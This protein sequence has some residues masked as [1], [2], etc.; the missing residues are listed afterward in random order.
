M[1]QRKVKEKKNYIDLFCGCGGL[2][3]GLESAGF[4]LIFANELSPMAAETYAYNLI[5][6]TRNNPSPENSPHGIPY[7]RFIN[8]SVN[9]LESKD[10]RNPKN[11]SGKYTSDFNSFFNGI[12]PESPKLLVGDVSQLRKKIEKKKPSWL[13]CNK[14]DLLAGGPPCQSFSLA[15]KREKDN[16]R[17]KLFI[18][19]VKIAKLTKPKIVLL[20]NVLG[21]TAPFT[22]KDGTKSYPWLDV[23]KEFS[24]AGYIP[25]PSLINAKD[26]GVPQ[27]RPR[28]ILICLRKD[29]IKYLEKNDIRKY[30]N[31]FCE[32]SKAAI[33]N[34]LTLYNQT[35][36]E[37]ESNSNNPVIYRPEE[38]DTWPT[39]IFPKVK[40]HNTVNLDDALNFKSPSSYNKALK[41]SLKRPSWI[42][43]NSLPPLN[44]QSRTHGI[45]TRARFRILRNL[46]NK[47]SIKSIKQVIDNADEAYEELKNKKVIIIQEDKPKRSLSKRKASRS[48]LISLLESLEICSENNHTKKRDTL[49]PLK[50][51]FDQI[52]ESIRN[53]LVNSL[54]SKR[55]KLEKRL[56]GLIINN[57]TDD[58][59]IIKEWR[60]NNELFND[61][62]IGKN[63]LFLSVI[64]QFSET[65]DRKLKNKS[66]FKK[67]LSLLKSAKQIQRVL[68]PDNPAP[69]QLSIPDDYIHWKEDRVLTI[70][71]MARI[72][73]FPDWFEFRSKETTGGSSRSF[74]VP[75]Y[76]QVGNAVPPLLALELGKSIYKLLENL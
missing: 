45:Q 39:S 17:N 75:Q 28:F 14:V 40:N 10:W 76:T 72:Q 58:F 7:F 20:E 27:S 16:P 26:Y 15:G 61:L 31:A 5:E 71:E 13:G 43:E 9:S 67:L 33:Q 19:F 52:M 64:R 51:E 21:I 50:K 56:Y 66:E 37:F 32:K 73:S 57:Q 23:C 70:R 29:I 46:R 3:L 34:G 35:E 60:K 49:L 62:F 6:G 36:K 48:A 65:G 54:K 11:R 59:L 69:A 12:T 44:H 2:S 55:G 63:I 74:E 68:D 53:N 1:K 30:N 8:N 47:P 18:E 24:S 4:N 22:N 38:N 41:N 25:I 42:P